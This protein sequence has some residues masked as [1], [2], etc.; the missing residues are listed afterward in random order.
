M[1]ATVLWF[2]L[3]SLVLAGC[4]ETPAP[5]TD[6]SVATPDA[7]GSPTDA[8]SPGMDAHAPGLDASEPVADAATPVTSTAICP[9]PQV[10]VRRAAGT[11]VWPTNSWNSSSLVDSATVTRSHARLDPAPGV[12]TTETV[13]ELPARVWGDATTQRSAF[14][15]PLE[16][17]AR[18]SAQPSH[19]S[20]RE[21]SGSPPDSVTESRNVDPSA[22]NTSSTVSPAVTLRRSQPASRNAEPTTASCWSTYAVVVNVTTL[23][24]VLATAIG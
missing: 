14:V 1:R 2:L 6:A 21:R 3:V 11:D 15:G 12:T 5:G 9:A 8:A 20:G 19:A 7:T 22:S 23:P 10:M 17:S 16:S 24:T 13:P 18:S 4:G